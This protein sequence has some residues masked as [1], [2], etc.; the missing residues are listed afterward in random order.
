MLGVV[1]QGQRPFVAQ[2]GPGG[3][4]GSDSQ[5]CAKSGIELKLVL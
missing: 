1:I 4:L 3:N 2:V 5:F